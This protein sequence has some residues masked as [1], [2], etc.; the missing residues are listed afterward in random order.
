MTE[1][2]EKY[3]RNHPNYYCYMEVYPEAINGYL[4][5]RKIE[6]DPNWPLERRVA[7]LQADDKRYAETR[8]ASCNCCPWGEDDP[9]NNNSHVGCEDCEP[10]W[11][12]SK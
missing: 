9:E 4:E 8:E 12:E 1:P 10:H 2:E 3:D 6:F 11:V 7:L 5:H